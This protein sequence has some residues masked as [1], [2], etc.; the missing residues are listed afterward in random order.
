MRKNCDLLRQTSSR[1][2]TAAV[3]MLLGLLVPVL[4][5]NACSRPITVAISPVG[6]SMIVSADATVSGVVTE[7][8]DKV[9]NESSCKFEYRIVPRARAWMLLASGKVDIV[10]SAVQSS[11][12]DK[13][14][15]LVPTHRLR[16][17]AIRFDPQ[18]AALTNTA[19]VLRQQLH[20][21]VVRAYDFGN[22]YSDLLGKLKQ[23][24]KLHEA[25]DPAGLISMLSAGRIDAAVVALPAVAD[26][27]ENA[28]MA[29]QIRAWALDDVTQQ[30]IGFYLSS[31]SVEDPDYRK[32]Q[33][34]LKRAVGS[35]K[36]RQLM[37]KHYPEWSLA[38][39]SFE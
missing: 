38:G 29:G 3:G 27:I 1:W 22:S 6:R 13:Q 35:G 36:F 2:R 33:A 5:A 15:L 19:G 12:R 16:V 8:L 7:F 23:S 11:I 17:A 9:S 10:P 4:E 32:L 14:G 24:G 18:S 25:A 20:V 31:I 21:G 28:G 26:A 34:A 30:Q 37:Q 39:V